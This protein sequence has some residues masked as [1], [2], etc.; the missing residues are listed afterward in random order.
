MRKK[1]SL[2]SKLANN[3]SRFLHDINNSKNIIPDSQ[4]ESIS[5]VPQLHKIFTLS[6]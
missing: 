6:A 1:Y 3:E 5:S 4:N 2:A